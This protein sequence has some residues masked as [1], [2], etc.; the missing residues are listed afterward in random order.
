MGFISGRRSTSMTAI[1]PS[2]DGAPHYLTATRA[3]GRF[4]SL[5]D[6]SDKGAAGVRDRRKMDHKELYRR[7]KDLYVSP[8]RRPPVSPRF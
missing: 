6:L 4:R 2:S 1:K 5:N 7:A 8:A 3:Q